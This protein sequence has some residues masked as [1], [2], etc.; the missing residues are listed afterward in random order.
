M[1]YCSIPMLIATLYSFV[2][3][4]FI[5]FSIICIYIKPNLIACESLLL[6]CLSAIINDLF[7]KRIYKESRPVTSR[8][9]GYGMPS[10][11]VTCSYATLIVFLL[12]FWL[13]PGGYYGNLNS[14][15]N[16]DY[17]NFIYMF[18]L[19]EACKMSLF[20]IILFFP[21]PWA[22]YKVGDH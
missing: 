21:M 17:K 16:L 20:T 4:F 13:G 1:K 6:L 15:E 14:T 5:L 7:I 19:S 3:H 2:P 11:H 8:A 18:D 12:E 9:H 10:S 22:R